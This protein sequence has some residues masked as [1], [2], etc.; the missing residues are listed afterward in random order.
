MKRASKLG[1]LRHFYRDFNVRY[2][3]DQGLKAR[4]RF[5]RIA[6]WS[7]VKQVAFSSLILGKDSQSERDEMRRQIVTELERARPLT[8]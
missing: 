3:R 5:Q 8:R 4:P 7:T 2:R 1:G 6:A